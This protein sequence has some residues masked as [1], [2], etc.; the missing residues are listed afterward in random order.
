MNGYNRVILMGNIG[1]EPEFRT[2]TNGS[3]LNFRM[4]TTESYKDNS[5]ARKEK[6]DWHS[7][8][9]WGKHGESLAKIVS[10][11]MHVLVEGSLRTR[12]YD[13]DGSKRYVT[14]VNA[15]VVVLG[16]KANNTANIPKDEAQ[17]VSP[18]DA[19]GKPSPA[20][21]GKPMVEDDYPF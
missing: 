15:D 10:K 16:P 20:N 17:V 9:V 14:E 18:S 11:G 5:G 19:R 3:V 6:T 4:A 21:Q 8:V 13:K 7:I 2:F 12:T 1:S